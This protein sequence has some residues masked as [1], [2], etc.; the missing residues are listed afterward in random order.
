[1]FWGKVCTLL[2]V[3]IVWFIAGASCALGN[4]SS[5]LWLF[6]AVYVGILSFCFWHE[7]EIE[8]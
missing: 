3:A 4:W 5:L 7:Y 2:A 1:M 6:V 8:I